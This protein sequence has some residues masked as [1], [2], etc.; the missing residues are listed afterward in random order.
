MDYVIGLGSVWH[1]TMFWSCDV[2]KFPCVSLAV[3]DVKSKKQ[4]HLFVIKSECEPQQ[5]N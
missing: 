4:L 3:Y 1:L 2:M 5:A